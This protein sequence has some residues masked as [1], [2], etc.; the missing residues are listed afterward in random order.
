MGKKT[1]LMIDPPKGSEYG[2]P[3]LHRKTGAFGKLKKRNDG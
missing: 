3:H 2:F 1:V